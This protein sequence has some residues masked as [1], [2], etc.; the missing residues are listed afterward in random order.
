MPVPNEIILAHCTIGIA[1]T[2][3]FIIRNHFETEGG[4]GIQGILPTGD[5]TIV[6]CGSESLDEYYLSTGT[7]VENT[8]Y[9]NM[10]RTQVRIKN[11]L[12]LPTI[13]SR[14]RWATT[15]SCCMAITRI[16]WKSSCKPMPANGLNDYSFASGITTSKR[17]PFPNS[18]ET[19]I[20]PCRRST[21][22]WQM[23]SPKPA[24]CVKLSSL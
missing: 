2:E 24:P 21:M 13:S 6:K 3:Q 12:P 23:L 8:N 14:H 15:T 1:Q 7:L 17:V 10:C 9:I 5:V 11:E 20:E 22:V 16:Y 18:E 19:E 4:I